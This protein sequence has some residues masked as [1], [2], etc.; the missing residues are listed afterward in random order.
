MDKFEKYSL[1]LVNEVNNFVVHKSQNQMH[2]IK[3]KQYAQALQSYPKCIV[4]EMDIFD[5]ACMVDLEM[6]E[7][8]LTK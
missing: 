3:H 6:Y 1:N 2:T 7:Q 8:W 4:D 5:D